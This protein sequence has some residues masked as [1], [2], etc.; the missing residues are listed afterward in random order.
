MELMNK[1]TNNYLILIHVFVCRIMYVR[2]TRITGIFS[3]ILIGL[4][5][6]LLPYPLSYIPRAV[7]N[8]LFLYLAITALAT[9]QL[10]ERIMLLVTEQVRFKSSYLCVLSAK[11][12]LFRPV[13][14][15]NNAYPP[16]HNISV[17]FLVFSGH[18]CSLPLYFSMFF[19]IFRPPT[20][21]TTIFQYVFLYFQAAYP[22]NHYI[23]VCFLVFSGRLPP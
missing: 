11:D 8:G 10:F 23:S 4:S 9:N 22:P 5:L 17:Y 16:N 19:G 2:E 1:L 18:L 15:E 21:L 14:V 12:F 13:Y 7:L 20:P 6:L 3:H